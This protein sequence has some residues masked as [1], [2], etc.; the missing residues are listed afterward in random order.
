[1]L[2][3]RYNTPSSGIATIRKKKDQKFQNSI[4]M[5]QFPNFTKH[6]KIVFDLYLQILSHSQSDLEIHKP[7]PLQLKTVLTNVF[8]GVSHEEHIQSQNQIWHGS[9]QPKYIFSY[10]SKDKRMNQYKYSGTLRIQSSGAGFLLQ[11][12]LK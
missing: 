2:L 7:G 11:T 4:P 8:R 3:N 12:N 6:K 1:M 9:K 5:N 10:K